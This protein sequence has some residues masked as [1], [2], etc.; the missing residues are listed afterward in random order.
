MTFEIESSDVNYKIND[1][2]IFSNK[3]TIVK[4][5]IGNKI[6]LLSFKYY[7]K[8]QTLNGK[9]IEI[10]DNEK[11]KYILSAGIVRLK[12]YELLGK[13]IKVLLR[14]D[15]YGNSKNEPN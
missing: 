11:H 13:D 14:N 1:A 8:T 5:K 3:K 6:S 10:E 15:I 2:E 12:K 4:D 7:N 9:E